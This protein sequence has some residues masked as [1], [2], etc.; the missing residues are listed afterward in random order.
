MMP[1]K[2]LALL[3]ASGKKPEMEEEEDEGGADFEAIGRELR[4]A[5]KDDDDAAV[6]EVLKSLMEVLGE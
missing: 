6:G 3:I 5:I 2:G 1:K 4:L